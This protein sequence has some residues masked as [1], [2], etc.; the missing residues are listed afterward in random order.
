MA[1]ATAVMMRRRLAVVGR[2]LIPVA[3]GM[4][5]AGGHIGIQASDRLGGVRDRPRHQR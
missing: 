3:S 4:T 1:M 5:E 2:H